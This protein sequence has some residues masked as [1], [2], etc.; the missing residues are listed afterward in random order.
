MSR[1]EEPRPL[2][3]DIVLADDLG[4]FRPPA[5]YAFEEELQGPAPRPR[6]DLLRQGR[7][8]S[9]QR[10]SA[11][12]LLVSGALMAALGA[13]PA[14]QTMGL[15]FLPLAYLTWIGLV[16]L[17]FGGVAFVLN[18]LRPGPYRYVE[19]G[20]PIVARIQA[21]RLVPSLMHEGQATRYRF[22]ALIE[23]PDP[24]TGELATA[25]VQ[26]TDFM[27]DS[28]HGLT[29]SFRVGDYVTAVYLPHDPAKTLRLYGFLDLRPNLG[30][31]R[32][33][34]APPS[35]PA[36][37]L[38]G[39][40]AIASFFVVLFWNVYAFGRYQP[41]Q[42]PFATG[43]VV[44]AVGAVGLGGL[45]LWSLW[46]NQRKLRRKRDERNAEA[47]ARGEAIEPE[48]GRKR[49]PFGNFGLFVTAIL[50]FGSLMLGGA[51]FFCWA[52]TAN[53]WLDRSAPTRRPVVIDEM[54]EV[55]HKAIFREYKIKYHFADD[56][57][58]KHEFLSNPSHMETFDGPLAV[59]EVGA[60][61][62]GWPWV[63]DIRPIGQVFAPGGV[64]GP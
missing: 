22:D 11:W 3:D 54:V 4:P 57:Q 39:V 16:V 40:V 56:P 12:A 62:F 64:P 2:D 14:V 7:Y 23:Y 29:T 25:E 1:P 6:P 27:A 60:G 61:A 17:A 36:K 15:Y 49:G 43:A 26:S 13:L 33:D 10:T 34:G 58:A 9:K 53:A 21:L 37:T 41:V 63:K 38:L 51:T 31:V 30:L 44:G 5:G 59:A 8:A 42:V 45:L 19:E 24:E 32:R 46:A 20:V 55:T 52:A 50:L 48:I 35:S 47:I 18:A 28:R